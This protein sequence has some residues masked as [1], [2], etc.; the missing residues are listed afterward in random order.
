MNL[1]LTLSKFSIRKQILIS[2][3]PVLLVLLFLAISS[4][5]TFKTFSKNTAAFEEITQEN[6]VFLDIEKDIVELQRNALVYS[7]I[8]YRGVLKKIESLQEELKEKFNLIK[9]IAYQDPEIK[10]RFDRLFRNY[11]QY[12]KGF[13]EAVKEKTS[14]QVLNDTKF[15]PLAQ[16]SHA[17]LN[18]IK[19]DFIQRDNFKAAYLITQIEGDLSKADTNI[20]SFS[21]TPDSFFIDDTNI[22]LADIKQNSEALKKKL[23]EKKDINQIDTFLQILDE[24]QVIFIETIT[25]NRVYL[26]LINV[27]LAGKAAEMDKLSGELD[28]LVKQR[29]KA[30][31]QNISKDI[32]SSRAYFIALS[33]IAGLIGIL[34][35]IGIATAIANPVN[36]MASTLSA[37]AKGHSDTLIPGQSRKDEVGEMAKAA[38][39]FKDM[40]VQLESQTEELEEFAYRTSHDLRSPLVSSIALLDITKGALNEGNTA[41]AQQSIHLVQD[42]LAK[43][44]LLVKDILELSKTKNMNEDIQ[45]VDLNN[46]IN[47]ALIKFVNIENFH[48]LDIQKDFDFKGTLQT[49]KSR[50][51]L[52]AENLISNA[53][54][55]QDPKKQN[56]FIKISTL[57]NENG[58]ELS[59]ED[60]GLGVPENQQDKLFT[61]FKRFHPRVSFGSGLGLY[62]IKKSADILRAK[63]EFKD[64]GNGSIFKLTVPFKPAT[65]N[66]P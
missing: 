27:V 8:G 61:M 23:I 24:Y 42:S 60:N 50:I 14:L 9:P 54:K 55:Y 18:N 52:I 29:S 4:Y 35:A 63:I 40:A 25:I 7:Y 64:T 12:N 51:V 11:R 33:F 48:R 1:F 36:A 26:H 53:I 65:V 57:Q 32:Q 16:K 15:K 58:I 22:L 30:L 47:E 6:L 28:G 43:L 19:K 56:S 38:N 31:T 44:E 20:K 17:Q 5:N 10:S 41:Q 45:P 13:E 37:L 59:V 49:Q 62:M 66:K 34:S 21:V 3:I 39:E 2:Y 46:I